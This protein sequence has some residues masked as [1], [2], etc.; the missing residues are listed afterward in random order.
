LDLR[1]ES[2]EES[3]VTEF[4]FKIRFPHFDNLSKSVRLKPGLHVIYGDSGVGKS[5][6]CQM[7]TQLNNNNEN[8]NFKISVVSSNEDVGF[9]LQ[10]PDD[11]VVAPTLFRELAF[12]FEN[13]GM[14][15]KEINQAIFRTVARSDLQIDLDRHPATLSGGEKELVN[16]ATA[17]ST[18][19]KLLIID[20][21]FAF[22]SRKRKIE[23]LKQLKEYADNQKAII[24][25]TT[26]TQEDLSY[27]KT[28]WELKLNGFKK[29]Y[30]KE[31]DTISTD[32]PNGK[33]FLQCEKLT[34]GYDEKAEDLFFQFSC[35]YGPFRSIALVGENGSGKTTL[36]RLISNVLKPSF[37]SVKL[38]LGN[39]KELRI[40]YLPQFPE[41][42]FGGYSLNEL[43]IRMRKNN[44]LSE[45]AE[46][47]MKSSLKQFTISWDL[48]KE[49]PMNDLKL[50]V[51][52]ICLLLMLLHARYDI[53]VL[54]EPMFSL[55]YS[56]RMKVMEQLRDSMNRKH[57]VIISHSDYFVRRICDAALVI[58]NGK[59]LSLQEDVIHA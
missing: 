25:W 24:I 1:Q 23:L 17:L 35:K 52:R 50:S 6:F 31:T 58:E 45:S 59:L 19:P 20:D 30:L 13:L 56:Q 2:L 49:Y 9:V 44:L 5:A 28:K 54:D 36:C 41:R 53:L 34:F 26:A 18:N 38:L 27:G 33:M 57:F 11:Q 14:E 32:I 47:F 39:R 8:T 22:L 12:N 42:M 37:G 55:G 21:G 16:L 51:S 43:M 3:F 48:I 7:L 29:S 4:I 40:G 46:L 10:D 15:S